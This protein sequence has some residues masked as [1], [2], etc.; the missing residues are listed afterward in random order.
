[1]SQCFGRDD[2][3]WNLSP[4][5][6]HYAG[7]RDSVTVQY[8][9][10]SAAGAPTV[11]ALLQPLPAPGALVLPSVT[12]LSADATATFLGMGNATLAV[13]PTH[14]YGRP[15]VEITFPALRPT[16]LPCEFV[17]SIVLAHAQ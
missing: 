1:M 6:G 9:I 2:G 11:N 10:P 8:T 4:E 16:E 12:L 3:A 5:A 7:R 15:G 17:Y 13:K 14:G